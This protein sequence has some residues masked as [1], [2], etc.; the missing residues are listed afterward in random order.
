MQDHA[1]PPTQD[2]IETRLWYRRPADHF[3]AALPIGNGRLGTM[4]FGSV[5]DETL[6]INDDCFWAGVAPPAPSPTG[7]ADLAQVRRL[8]AGGDRRGA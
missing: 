1:M 2:G 4:V 6:P 8:I 3:N 5:G 7:P